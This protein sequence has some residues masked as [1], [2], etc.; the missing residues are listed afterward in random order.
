MDDLELIEMRTAVQ[1][2]DTL[3]VIRLVGV[4]PALLT[5]ST[6]FGSWLHI[7]VSFGRLQMVEC[8][9]DLGIDRNAKGGP[10]GGSPLH[11]AAAS[12]QIEL[13]E[14]LLA[15]GVEMDVSRAETNPLFGAIY[16]GHTA[17][18]RLLIDAGIDAG[19]AMEGP[20][21][22]TAFEYANQCGRGEIAALLT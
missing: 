22:L 10:V 14:H 19:R 4:N 18:V 16:G 8:L 15:R 2:N 6:F 13:V 21:Q 20:K 7:A 5:T 9:I 3:S 11:L 1:E 17:V 12:G